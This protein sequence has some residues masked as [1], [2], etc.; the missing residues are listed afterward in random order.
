MNPQY[1]E[2]VATRIDQL[3]Y[4]KSG[5]IDGCRWWLV[6]LLGG[7]NPYESV[8]VTRIPIDDKE[9]MDRLWKQKRYLFDMFG[10]EPK[11]LLIGGED[12]EEM[13]NSPAIQQAMTF[14]ASFHYGREIY[15]LTVKIIPWM[16]GAVVMP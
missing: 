9:F 10:R 2:F 6:K 5:W 16:R 7:E 13:M 14:Q 3:P 4:T 12:Y 11:T 8:K 15:G 1:F